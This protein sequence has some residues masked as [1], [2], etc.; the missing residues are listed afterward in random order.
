MA[1]KPPTKAPSKEPH[2]VSGTSSVGVGVGVTTEVGVGVITEV[3]VR[4]ITAVGEGVTAMVG[5]GVETRV[6][7]SA[8][9]AT[10]SLVG[11]AVGTPVGVEVGAVVGVAVGALVEVA[12][13]DLVGVAVGSS[14]DAAVGVSSV[15]IVGVAG[16]RKPVKKMRP[17]MPNRPRIKRPT[18]PRAITVKILLRPGSVQLFIFSLLRDDIYR[19]ERSNSSKF[20]RGTNTLT[21]TLPSSSRST[22]TPSTSAPH[23]TLLWRGGLAT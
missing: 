17:P 7:V 19:V 21:N 14:V 20:A 22:S 4:V 23:S 18:K 11:V 6:A 10:G 2:P 3:G 1:R 9:V 5:K 15:T 13:G 12:V 16:P 8:G